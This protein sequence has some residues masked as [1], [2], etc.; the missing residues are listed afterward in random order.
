MK[1]NEYR[2]GDNNVICDYSGQKLKRSQCKRMWN[3]LFVKS[4]F[5]ERRHP[6]DL[7]Q[8]RV[9]KQAAPV[10]RPEST[11]SFLADNEVTAD[12]L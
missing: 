5:W 11:D 8:T 7:I 10:T 3:G 12:S 9:D 4:E 2:H 6:Q 1:R